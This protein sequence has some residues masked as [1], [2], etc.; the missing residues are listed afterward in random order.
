MFQSSPGFGAGRYAIAHDH[1]LLPILFQ[2]SPGFGAGRYRS[3]AFPG[4]SG[5]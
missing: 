5:E 2:S 4:A 1:L 3:L